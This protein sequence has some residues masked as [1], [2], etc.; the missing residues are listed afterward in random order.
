MGIGVVRRHFVAIATGEY[1]DPAYG[2]LPV[3][4]EVSQLR[5]WVLDAG[6]LGDRAFTHSVSRAG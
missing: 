1:D 6:R 3:A 2:P 5:A 4:E